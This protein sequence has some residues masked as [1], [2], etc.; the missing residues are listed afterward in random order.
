MHSNAPL[1]SGRRVKGGALEVRVDLF[2]ELAFVLD[3]RCDGFVGIDGAELE[4]SDVALEEV[5]VVV[6]DAE[7]CEGGCSGSMRSCSSK[8]RTML[9]DR[10]SNEC[11]L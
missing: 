11:A 9:T 8:E 3:A 2:V 6:G 10:S 4:I 1:A 5:P 7:P